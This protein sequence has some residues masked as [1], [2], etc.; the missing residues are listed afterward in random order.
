[1]KI[2]FK[3]ITI[4]LLA[5]CFISIKVYGQSANSKEDLTDKKW[6]FLTEAYFL[7]PT[8]KGDTGIGD[9]PDISINAGPSDILGQLSMGAMLYF[10]AGTNKWSITSDIIYM[11]LGKGL[12]A[13]QSLIVNY[14]TIE[15]KQFM[16]EVTGLRKL[17]PCLDA[18]IGFRL[19]NLDMS[20]DINRNTISGPI[21]QSRSGSKT[22]LDPI[23][24]ARFHNKVDSK[25][26]YQVRGDIGGFSIGS[27]FSWQ[28]Q[29]YLGY[30]ISDLFQA[31]AGYRYIGIDYDKGNGSDRFL[32][33]VDTSGPVIRVGFNF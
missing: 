29:A 14:G 33:D 17:F 27:D 24:V 16:W 21:D 3:S 18:G 30:R 12:D 6:N 1:M 25:F 23:I 31:T 19:N 5:F 15:L 32:Y 22:W 2:T 10:E 13:E 26:L 4:L 11:N 20:S 7:F 8:M 28:M 9:L